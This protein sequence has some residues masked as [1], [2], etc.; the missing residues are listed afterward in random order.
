M[1]TTFTSGSLKLSGYLAQPLRRDG[2]PR[3]TPRSAVIFCHGF[4]AAVGSAKKA[5]V[6]YHVLADRIVEDMGWT[7]FVPNYR[8]CGRSEGNFSLPGWLEDIRAAVEHVCTA[9]SVTSVWVAGFG[10]GATLGLTAAADLTQVAG[11]VSVAAR[12]DFVGWETNAE[13]LLAHSRNVGVVSDDDFP[14]DFD[15]WAAG[16]RGISAVEAAG[17]L[18]PRPLLIVH[19][20]DDELVK[21]TDARVIADAHGTADLRVLHAGSHRLRYDPRCISLVLGWLDRRG[22]DAVPMAASR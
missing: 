10:T 9:A 4:P 21:P 5:G 2:V 19:G 17:R 22:H 1:E 14:A 20:A 13:S 6:S 16:L 8:G 18:A 11:A 3:R 12:A 7:A 15:E